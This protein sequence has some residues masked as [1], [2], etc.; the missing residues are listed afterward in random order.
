MSWTG[1]AL[2]IA[3]FAA[4]LFASTA[5]AQAL[6][7]EARATLQWIKRSADHR[8][9]P[10]AVVDK[11]AAMLHVFDASAR[12]VGSSVVLL[13]QTMGDE[14]DPEVGR[15]TT[16]GHVPRHQR[17]T[18]AGRFVS[19]PGINLTGEAIVWVDYDSAFA[20]HRLRPGASHAD[21]ARRLASPSVQD[22]RA[23]L[24]CV[25]VPVAFYTKVVA[26]VLGHRRAVVYVLPEAGS[27][28]ASVDSM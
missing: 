5:A 27:Q 25:V 12:S 13:G 3:A 23:S 19:S 1:R 14:V 20:I 21:R 2:C 17:T 7:A 4:S 10:F 15:N 22:N 8:G 24:G 16:L 18:P 9:M 26:R 28:G 11:K 6:S